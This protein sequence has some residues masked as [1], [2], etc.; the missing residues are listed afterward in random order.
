MLFIL[1]TLYTFYFY[2]LSYCAS[3]DQQKYWIDSSQDDVVKD[4]TSYVK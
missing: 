4:F 2:F 1:S 3:Y